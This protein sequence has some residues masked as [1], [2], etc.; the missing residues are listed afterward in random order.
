MILILS[1][2]AD[3]DFTAATC[4]SYAILGMSEVEVAIKY[5]IYEGEEEEVEVSKWK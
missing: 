1:L 5:K 3:L 4:S 2:S